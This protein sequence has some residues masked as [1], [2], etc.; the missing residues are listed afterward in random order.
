MCVRPRG[1]HSWLLA[2]INLQ[3]VTFSSRM[4]PNE[5]KSL[6]YSP[7]N[8]PSAYKE[9]SSRRELSSSS[10]LYTA[11][12]CGNTPCMTQP[13]TPR[14]ACRE[15]KLPLTRP[16]LP[17]RIAKSWKH[18]PPWYYSSAS[19][20][21]VPKLGRAQSEMFFSSLTMYGRMGPS[22]L[23]GHNPMH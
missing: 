9:F 23:K 22:C 7:S 20:L 17:S 15:R 19:H 8:Y 18:P 2:E 1:A 6:Y 3:S 21:T 11:V 14:S 10:R 13:S 16:P 4:F 12:K 5:E